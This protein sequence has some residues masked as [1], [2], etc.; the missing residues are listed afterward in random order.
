MAT[1][2]LSTWGRRQHL[3][4]ALAALLLV[5]SGDA[6]SA[7]F[8]PPR[9]SMRAAIVAAAAAHNGSS[10]REHLATKVCG[11]CCHAAESKRHASLAGGIACVRQPNA[12][13]GVSCS[14]HTNPL[15]AVR[16]QVAHAA[17]CTLGVRAAAPGSTPSSFHVAARAAR[18]PLVSWGGLLP[19]SRGRPGRPSG[20]AA[21][22][23]VAL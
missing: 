5:C 14:P 23:C 16:A 9:A 12:L 15:G 13:C 8:A 7:L 20:V 10:L 17:A 19:L 4:L 21:T 18:Q 2:P 11:V 3:F 22:A 6:V 1:P